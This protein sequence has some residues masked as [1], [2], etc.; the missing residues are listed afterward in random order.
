MLAGIL[1]IGLVIG[2]GGFRDRTDTLI[3][4][5]AG[6]VIEAG[7]YEFV[8]TE[9]TAKREKQ[10]DDKIIWEVQAVGQAHNTGTVTISPDANGDSGMFV[11]RDPVTREVQ[12]STTSDVGEAEG[13]MVSTTKL[14]PSLPP[15]TFKVSFEFTD[16]YEPSETILFGVN[17]IEFASRDIIGDEKRWGNG[18]YIYRMDLPVTVLPEDL[19]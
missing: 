9:A 16:K 11:A 13:F 10:Y 2:F 19:D 8:F 6:D 1:V 4:V 17:K 5:A 15:V 12:V 14:T 3:D 18:S 7:P